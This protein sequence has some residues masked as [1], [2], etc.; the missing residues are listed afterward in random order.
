MAR[1][2]PHL[3]PKERGKEVSRDSIELSTIMAQRP[4]QAVRKGYQRPEGGGK[5]VI[6]ASKVVGR[7]DNNSLP[8]TRSSLRVHAIT[9]PGTY[10]IPRRT[11]EDIKKTPEELIM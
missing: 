8:T 9:S 5:K 2:P 3:K 10:K 6:G 11:M 4:N 7:K 1:A